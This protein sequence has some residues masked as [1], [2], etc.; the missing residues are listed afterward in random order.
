MP[1]RRRA[2]TLIELLTVM[3]ISGVLAGIL[4]PVLSSVRAKAG[5]AR[6]VSNLRQIGVAFQL[7]AGD[8]RGRLGDYRK[9]SGG[10]IAGMRYWGG[11]Q[12]TWGYPSKDRVLYPY[13]PDPEVFHCPADTGGAAGTNAGS[14]SWEQAGNS[15]LVQNSGTRGIIYDSQGKVPGIIEQIEHPARTILAFDAT[16]LNS[17]APFSSSTAEWHPGGRSNVVMV[18]GHV[19]LLE[20][21]AAA[22]WPLNP[23]GYSWGWRVD[24]GKLNQWD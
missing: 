10:V 20:K 15:Y 17:T 4:F 21:T 24:T 13:L 22:K 1:T 19:A 5:N 16:L 9:T 11:K 2:F 3:A 12:G 7:Y 14:S 23:A 6:C 18:D 8:N